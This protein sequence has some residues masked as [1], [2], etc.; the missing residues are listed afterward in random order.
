MT[1]RQTYW[2]VLLASILAARNAGRW[3]SRWWP[4]PTA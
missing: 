1:H 4:S 2:L 3:R